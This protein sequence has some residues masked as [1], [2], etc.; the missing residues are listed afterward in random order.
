MES[1]TA[2]LSVAGTLVG[3]D[4]KIKT[5]HFVIPD[6]DLFRGYLDEAFPLSVPWTVNR[7]Y[8]AIILVET[9]LRFATGQETK[10]YRLR[11]LKPV[12]RT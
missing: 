5:F 2:T 11:N 1:D 6:G 12:E 10:R 8:D 4:S 7:Q 9:T 3:I